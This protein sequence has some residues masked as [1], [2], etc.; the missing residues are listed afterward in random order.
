MYIVEMTVMNELL[1]LNRPQW[2]GLLARAPLHMLE[3]AVESYTHLSYE[4]LKPFEIVSYMI[5]G[6]T[7]STGQ[8]FNVGEVTV[9]RTTLKLSLP[10]HQSSKVQHY[11]G[12]A[13]IKG[14]GERQTHLAALGDA[15]LQDSYHHE[16]LTRT[17]LMPVSAKLKLDLESVN[18]KV[19]ATKVD[20][21]TI[22]RENNASE[23]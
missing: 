22:A 20:F 8:R 3:N 13:Y 15:L 11:I 2:L 16:S 10:E 17:L 21:F 1:N 18:R 6:R 5:Q 7:G 19:Q 14:G 4:I 23:V 12:V 9:S